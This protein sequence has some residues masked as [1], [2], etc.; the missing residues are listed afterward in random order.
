VALTIRAHKRAREQGH[1]LVIVPGPAR[2]QKPFELAGL[3]SILEFR[4]DPAAGPPA[5]VRPD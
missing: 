5:E 4:D 3:D 2:V 1:R